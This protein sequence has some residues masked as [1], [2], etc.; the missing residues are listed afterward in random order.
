MKFLPVILLLLG[1]GAGF[2]AGVVLAP[3]RPP[4]PEDAPAE[5]G[6]LPEDCEAPEAEAADTEPDDTEPA[7]FVRMSNQFVIPVLEGGDVRAIVVLSLT[8]EVDP[9]ATEAVFAIEPKLRDAF[10]RVLFDHANAGGFDGAY[11]AAGPMED[12]RR[13]LLEVARKT[14][15]AVVREVLVLDLLRQES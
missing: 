14:A 9:G 6:D 13:A 12:L 10:L 4:C 2:G 15:G 5:T 8:L 3:D 7:E 11:T 1:L